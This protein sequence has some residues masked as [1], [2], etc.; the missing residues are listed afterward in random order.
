MPTRSRPAAC[1]PQPAVRG[2]T[3]TVFKQVLRGRGLQR[4]RRQGA[5]RL[6]ELLALVDRNVVDGLVNLWGTI[7]RQVSNLQGA[8]DARVVD[9]AVNGVGAVAVRSGG[10]CGGCRLAA[11]SPTSS[12]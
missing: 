8:I 10:R 11:F 4:G 6:S 7:G 12:V 1:Q 3:A 9:G 5:R 2:S